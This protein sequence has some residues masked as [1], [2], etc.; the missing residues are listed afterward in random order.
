MAEKREEIEKIDLKRA[1]E[2][3]CAY[4][5]LSLLF[6]LFYGGVKLGHT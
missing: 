1:R 2:G 4:G 3:C 5:R 6:L